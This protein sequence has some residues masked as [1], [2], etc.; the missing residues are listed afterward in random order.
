MINKITRGHA[1][2][3]ACIL[4]AADNAVSIMAFEIF[5]PDWVGVFE[6]KREMTL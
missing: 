4:I 1:C 3:M 5:C 2:K 6:K